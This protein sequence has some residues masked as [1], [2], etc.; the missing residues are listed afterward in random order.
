MV[1]S[2]E[3]LPS[4]SPLALDDHLYLYK[5]QYLHLGTG[6]IIMDDY[7]LKKFF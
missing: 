7:H 5:C 6:D 4:P 3:Q 2:L 1:A